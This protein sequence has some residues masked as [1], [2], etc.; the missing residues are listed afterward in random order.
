MPVSIYL[1]NPTPKLGGHIFLYFGKMFSFP[2]K[3]HTQRNNSTKS[4]KSLEKHG[5]ISLEA[6]SNSEMHQ[7]HICGNIIRALRQFTK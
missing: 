5:L 6:T 3:S 2:I 4:S 7:R 1:V